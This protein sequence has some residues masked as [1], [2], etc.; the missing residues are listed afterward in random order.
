MERSK[1]L[2]IE[3]ICVGLLNRYAVAVGEWDSDAFV[4]V[5]TEDGIWQRPESPAMRGHAAIRAFIDANRPTDTLVR[6]VNGTA[7]IDVI[8]ADNARGI[9]YTTVYNY[10][11]YQ[12]GIAPMSGPDYIIEYRDHYCRRGDDWLI[13]RRDTTVVFRATYAF[14]LPG[15]PNPDR[16]K[17]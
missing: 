16:P 6:H 17:T 10:E 5:F 7:Q 15:I 3:Q 4:A 14:D 2:E 11:N 9:S 8:D 13:A 12:G 1:R